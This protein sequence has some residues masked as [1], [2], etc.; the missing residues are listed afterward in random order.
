MLRDKAP[1]DSDC[2]SI[3]GGIS[4]TIGSDGS[5]SAETELGSVNKDVDG[6]ISAKFDHVKTISIGDVTMLF[7]YQIQEHGRSTVHR[8][9]FRNGGHCYLV[10][11]DTGEITDFRVGKLKVHVSFDG[12]LTLMP[13]S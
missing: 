10:Y 13:Q 3:T 7:E 6:S 4:Y 9:K 5:W 12:I 11:T 1:K 8:V 2:T